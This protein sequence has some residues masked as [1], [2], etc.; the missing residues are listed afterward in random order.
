VRDGFSTFIN[1]LG[2]CVKPCLTQIV[3]SV[4]WQFNNKSA[5][6]RQQ[7]AD[8]TTRLAVVFKQCGEV[9]PISTLG[10][11]LFEQLGEEYP[12]TPDESAGQGS[13]A[14]NDTCPP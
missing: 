13:F 11:V 9:Q 3:S 1:A 10:L 5:K 12:D 8:L 14:P 7:A 4:L 2:T 6:V